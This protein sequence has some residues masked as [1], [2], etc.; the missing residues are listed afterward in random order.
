MIEIIKKEKK[1][2]ILKE[3]NKKGWLSFFAQQ[4]SEIP[5]DKNDEKMI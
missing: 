1:D 2:H 5:L 4:Q 3:K